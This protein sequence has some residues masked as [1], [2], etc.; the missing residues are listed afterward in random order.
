MNREGALHSSHISTFNEQRSRLQEPRNQLSS[1]PKSFNPLSEGAANL[2]HSAPPSITSRNFFQPSLFAEF[3]AFRNVLALWPAL[4]APFRGQKTSA[5][6]Y[7]CHTRQLSQTSLS[8]MNLLTRHF[9][10]KTFLSVLSDFLPRSPQ[11]ASRKNILLSEGGR[12]ILATAIASMLSQGFREKLFEPCKPSM[13]LGANAVVAHP[14]IVCFDI[15]AGIEGAASYGL[16]TRT[17][18]HGILKLHEMIVPCE[19]AVIEGDALQ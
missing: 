19:R 7:H 18:L 4:K 10:V 9:V 3:N 15:E 17:T 16:P 8:A 1:I 2:S 5:P 12:K 14:N 11:T 6:N 13:N